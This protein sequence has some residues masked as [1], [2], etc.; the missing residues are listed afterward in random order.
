M[1][2]NVADNQIIV[3]L[4]DVSQLDSMQPLTQCYDQ[5]FWHMNKAPFL[6][7]AYRADERIILLVGEDNAANDIT[8]ML[9]VMALI[10]QSLRGVDQ[11]LTLP[12]AD[13]A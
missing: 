10:K 5:M 12:Q 11:I 2:L 8:T 9:E 3:P 7:I 4:K 6:F 1:K 13:V